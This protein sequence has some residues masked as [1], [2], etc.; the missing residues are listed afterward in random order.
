M[1]S[2]WAEELGD[3]EPAGLGCLCEWC[4]CVGAGCCGL[5]I[6]LWYL[7]AGLKL[8]MVQDIQES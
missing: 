1:E 3:L 5:F 8:E 7:P 6:G 4:V 2:V